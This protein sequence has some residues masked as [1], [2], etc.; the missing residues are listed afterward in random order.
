[1]TGSR[2]RVSMS[3]AERER[4]GAHPGRSSTKSGRKAIKLPPAAPHMPEDLDDEAVAEWARV[5]PLL[6]ERGLLSEVD[7]AV[8]ASYC[9]AWSHACAAEKQLTEDGF[10]Q[11]DKNGDVRKNPVWQIW[12]ESTTL[13][14]VLG[15]ELLLTPSARLRASMPEGDGDGAEGASILD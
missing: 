12:R 6:H 2:G 15:K 5:V 8:A 3:D 4:K 9:R 11:T 7:R 13:A 10:T 1:M 14:A